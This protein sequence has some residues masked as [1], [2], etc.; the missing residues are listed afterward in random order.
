MQI[1]VNIAHIFNFLLPVNMGIIG[2]IQ[3]K[4]CGESTLL[5]IIKIIIDRNE[6][7]TISVASN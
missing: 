7:L 6:Y 5:V 1:T 4:Y 2:R 3:I